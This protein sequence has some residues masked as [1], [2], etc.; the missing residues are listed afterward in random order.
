[1]ITLIGYLVAT[2]MS[3]GNMKEVNVKIRSKVFKRLII[4]LLVYSTLFIA[5]L[6][7][8]ILELLPKA[9]ASIWDLPTVASIISFQE[10]FIFVLIANANN[11]INDIAPEIREQDSVLSGDEND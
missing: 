1:M 7:W 4:Q 8:L 3:L 11:R 5:V 9:E 6:L 10:G 2:V